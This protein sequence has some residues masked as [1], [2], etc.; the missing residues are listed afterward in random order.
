MPEIHVSAELAESHR[1]SS[2][3]E[4]ASRAFF[5]TLIQSPVNG[6]VQIVDNVRGTDLLPS[7]QLIDA[8]KEAQFASAAW[9]AQQ[10]GQAAGMIPWF[11]CLHKGSAALIR[12]VAGV[13]ARAV[14]GVAAE[15]GLSRVAVVGEGRLAGQSANRFLS[16]KT[17]VEVGASA[18][19]GLA[20]GGMLTP[21]KSDESPLHARFRNAASS[22]LT[23]ATLAGSARGLECAG[24]RS[25]TLAGALSG[26]PAGIVSAESHSL[27]DGK[28]LAS[29]RDVGKSVY[30]F[31]IIG[32]GFGFA[33]GR[34]EARTRASEKP[35]AETAKATE[36]S[37]TAPVPEVR[38]GSASK[39]EVAASTVGGARLAEVLPTESTVLRAAT[40]TTG[41]PA[42]E[43]AVKRQPGGEPVPG[44]RFSMACDGG[45]TTMEVVAVKDH[46][47]LLRRE[48][49]VETYSGGRIS[50]EELAARF[51]KIEVTVD[52]QPQ[53]RYVSSHKSGSRWPVWR[54]ETKGDSMRLRLDENHVGVERNQTQ[55]WVDT[56]RT[57]Q[58]GDASVQQAL[59]TIAELRA[60]AGRKELPSPTQEVFRSTTPEHQYRR[61]DWAS[62]VSRGDTKAIVTELSGT[63]VVESPARP[64]VAETRDGRLLTMESP[65]PWEVT[66]PSN[67]VIT[68]DARGDVVIRDW[69]G[70][71]LHYIDNPM[72]PERVIVLE[73]P[74]PIL[75][76]TP[77]TTPKPLG[78]REK[79]G[80]YPGDRTTLLNNGLRV[81]ERSGQP[82][83]AVRPDGTRFGQ[84][85]PGPWEVILHS[86][87]R[88]S[89][90][91]SGALKCGDRTWLPDG[92][93]IEENRQLMYSPVRY[94][95]VTSPSKSTTRIYDDPAVKGQVVTE[96]DR[97][98][99]R[100]G[101]SQAEW[102]ATRS[103]GTRFTYDSPGPWE[104]TTRSGERLSKDAEGNIKLYEHE[105]QQT[106]Y[107]ANGDK[108]FTSLNDVT[109]VKPDGTR[110][111]RYHSG[112][113]GVVQVTPDGRRTFIPDRKLELVKPASKPLPPTGNP[114]EIDSY[115]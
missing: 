110:L 43:L 93:L 28:G 36:G 45:A 15:S 20:Y 35:P 65:G 34:I 99:D 98:S 47:V 114:F 75:N 78:W 30:G 12:G 70:E 106:E 74:Y 39:P 72:A 112:S 51:D 6:V 21:V 2:S 49:P 86:G 53:I 67:R 90:D 102:E 19:S 107:R 109:I 69:R 56:A 22:A 8:P 63:I 42:V 80:A 57:R 87:T 17:A 89:K 96:F 73:Q 91:A 41:R 108:I 61:Y 5:Y 50:A 66:T 7:V 82:W 38:L 1:A 23:F 71:I 44:E 85:S 32:G 54:I 52:G 14:A 29:I 46:M 31:A 100:I 11:F 105:R 25:H 60:E 59:V 111:I 3:L 104:I 103:D 27:L 4:Q 88:Y 76:E 48:A 97:Y 18:L 40:T 62:V 24:L 113:N 55:Q 81:E 16:S 26:I 58:T 84:S 79:R 9:H 33:Q 37:T 115:W 92:T 77:R 83:E 68:K 10:I 95:E 13:E 101:G 94:K 64:W